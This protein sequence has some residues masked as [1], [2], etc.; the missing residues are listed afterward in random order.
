MRVK[1]YKGKSGEIT[2]RYRQQ[3]DVTYKTGDGVSVQE[4]GI[5]RRLEVEN[6]RGRNAKNVYSEESTKRVKTVQ[7][8]TKELKTH[9]GITGRVL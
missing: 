5:N 8:Y 2:G 9:V 1:D 4:K 6:K 3:K 7:D